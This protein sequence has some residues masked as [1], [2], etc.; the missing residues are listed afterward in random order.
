VDTITL[1]DVIGMDPQT[2]L[3]A[4][5]P[6]DFQVFINVIDLTQALLPK[7]NRNSFIQWAVPLAKSLMLHS[8][9]FPLVSGF[10]KLLTLCLDLCNN[11]DFFKVSNNCFNP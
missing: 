9:Q 3:K 5:K 2:S 4:S 1:L 11:I 7:I 10:Y 8:S 6:K